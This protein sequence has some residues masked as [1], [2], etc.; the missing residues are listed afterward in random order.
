MAESEATILG[1]RGPIR[2]TRNVLTTVMH[3][4]EAATSRLEDIAS[5][6]INSDSN[7]PQGGAQAAITANATPIAPAPQAPASLPPSIE[8][9]DALLNTELKAWMELSSKLGPVIQNQVRCADMPH[10]DHV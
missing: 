9:Y 5:T 1:R 3:R 4:L 7:A 2:V 6:S 8:A 10:L